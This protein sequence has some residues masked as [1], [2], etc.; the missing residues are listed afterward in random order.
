MFA[1][2]P[3]FQT[4]IILNW[5]EMVLRSSISRSLMGILVARVKNHRHDVDI[6][7]LWLEILKN[8]R[9][10]IFCH[11]AKGCIVD[12]IF[13]DPVILSPPARSLIR[14]FARLDEIIQHHS[15]VGSFQ[16]PFQDA[17][18]QIYTLTRRRRMNERR[19]CRSSENIFIHIIRI[20][21]DVGVGTQ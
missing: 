10:H 15:T 12:A 5:I 19:R 3:C 20:Y 9:D 8:W 6:Y 1:T 4:V 16:T 11:H 14:L 13:L 21:K 7:F 2:Q 18:I 17:V